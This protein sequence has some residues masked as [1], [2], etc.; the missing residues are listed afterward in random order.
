MKL[1]TKDITKSVLISSRRLYFSFSLVI[2]TGNAEKR[3]KI[4][5]I[6]KNNPK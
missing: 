3:I 5:A 2:H 1:K 6:E 4:A